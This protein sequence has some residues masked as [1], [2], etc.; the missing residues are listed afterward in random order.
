MNLKQISIEKQSIH[1]A[2]QPDACP[3]HNILFPSL[4]FL[5]TGSV[6]LQESQSDSDFV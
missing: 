2:E 4:I 3:L 1:M 5:H 6:Y